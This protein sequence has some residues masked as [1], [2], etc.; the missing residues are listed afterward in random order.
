MN[1]LINMSNLH[2]GGAIAVA[3][4]FCVYLNN[5]PKKNVYVV[6]SKKILEEVKKNNLKIPNLIEHDYTWKSFIFLNRLVKEKKNKFSFYF[7]WSNLMRPNIKHIVG[8]A[9][10]WLIYDSKGV[11]KISSPFFYLRKIESYIKSIIYKITTD[12]YV[13]ESADVKLNLKEIKNY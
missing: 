3:V 4:S 2:K 6:V 13:V 5:S 12:K 10:P 8:F 11:R 7:I 1:K 9:L